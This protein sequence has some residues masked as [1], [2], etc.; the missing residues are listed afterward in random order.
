MHFSLP[1]T[2]F[3]LSRSAIDSLRCRSEARDPRAVVI[4]TLEIVY[5]PLPWRLGRHGNLEGVDFDRSKAFADDPAGALSGV[6]RS[7]DF[8]ADDKTAPRSDLPTIAKSHLN[9]KRPHRR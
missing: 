9:G 8:G 4:V 6:A 7:L 5:R 3:K 1:K 2:D